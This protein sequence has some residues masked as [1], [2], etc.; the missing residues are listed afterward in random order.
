VRVEGRGLDQYD[1]ANAASVPKGFK[2]AKI[3]KDQVSCPHMVGV[4]TY[5]P[6]TYLPSY[7]AI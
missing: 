6:V 1:P 7:L 4:P 2:G 3:T 5:L